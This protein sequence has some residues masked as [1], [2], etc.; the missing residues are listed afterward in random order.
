MPRVALVRMLRMPGEVA[1]VVRR[2][3]M[4]GHTFLHE[5]ETLYHNESTSGDKCV[6][7]THIRTTR[8]SSV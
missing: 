4:R 3:G 1:L 6:L 7:K 8:F 2:V 5:W